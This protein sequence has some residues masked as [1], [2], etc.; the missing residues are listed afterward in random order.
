MPDES[1]GPDRARL[2]AA[3][4]HLNASRFGRAVQPLLAPGF[5]CPGWP[6]RE[7]VDLVIDCLVS[8][9]SWLLAHP[10][11][12]LVEIVRALRMATPTDRMARDI[13]AGRKGPYEWK[14]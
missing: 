3:G 13:R 9:N 12:T 1:E 14:R 11:V 7:I 2:M 8:G 5:S 4:R 6:K 10:H